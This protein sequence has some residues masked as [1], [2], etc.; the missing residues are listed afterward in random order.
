MGVFVNCELLYIYFAIAG[1][2][3]G[4][5]RARARSNRLHVTVGCTVCPLCVEAGV[6]HGT[7]YVKN[8]AVFVIGEA[9]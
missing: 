6:P 1:G 5:V 3:G 4:K 2:G 9:N 8:C 7:P